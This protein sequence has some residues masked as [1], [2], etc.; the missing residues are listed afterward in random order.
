MKEN[1]K[2]NIKKMMNESDISLES[3]D[4]N[5]DNMSGEFIEVEFHKK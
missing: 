5:E 3:V 1:L 2:S 4:S